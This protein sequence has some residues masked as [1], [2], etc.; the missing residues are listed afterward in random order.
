MNEH[1]TNTI[2][3]TA[4]LTELDVALEEFQKLISQA[5]LESLEGLWR[6]EADEEDLNRLVGLAKEWQSQV[7]VFH[8][9][10]LDYKE[11]FHSNF[12]AW[13]LRPTASHGLGATFLQAF[14]RSQGWRRAITAPL[15]G[16]TRVSREHS[17]TFQDLTGR[18]DIRILNEDSK[19]V[20]AIENK[21]WSPE[22]G[23]QLAFYRKALREQFP[24]HRIKR[25]FLTPAG[26][27]PEDPYEQKHWS[28]M[29]YRD[30][31]GLVEKT[32]EERGE[33]VHE[34]VRALLRQYATTLRRNIVPEVSDEMHRL[35]PQIYR[36]HR[37]AIDLII[38]HRERYEP[39]YVTEAF[40]MV[41][42][43]I[44]ERPEWTESRIDHPYARFMGT[45]WA[46]KE[47]LKVDGWPNFLLQFQVHC[48]NRRAELSLYLTWGENGGKLKKI[49]FDQ[50]SARPELFASK[51][52][53]D[54]EGSINL[55]IGNVLEGPDYET[56]W[57][58]DV[59]RKTISIRLE[60][61][62]QG[63]FKEINRIVVDCLEQYGAEIA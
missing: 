41:R 19:F 22:G 30:V 56:W 63:Q 57:D 53:D 58:E 48:T 60:E 44:G 50:L 15:L 21:V 38:E 25:V 39:N 12:L 24:G 34:D 36:K 37:Q 8:S 29:S 3:L 7:D 28:V 10:E 42:Y 47:E 2:A 6:L 32:L 52:P 23:E 27:L 46:D 61:F 16:V 31:L 45:E 11:E 20:C 62:A 54:S 43:A 13:L 35:A 59:T 40:R 1:V 33:A 17:V 49:I 5:D 26:T 9:L 14:L 51:F 55:R 4:S 18:L